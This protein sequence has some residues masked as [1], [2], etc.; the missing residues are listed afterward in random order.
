MI[1]DLPNLLLAWSIQATGVFSPGPGV[2]FILG[3]ATTAGRK[4]AL[5]AC[6]G[7]G[8]GALLLAVLTV[9]GFAAILAE[10]RPLLIATRWIGAAYLAWLAIGAFRRAAAPPPPPVA[11]EV[12]RGEGL[13]GRVLGGFIFQMGNPKA[14]FFWIAVAAV[15]ALDTVSTTSLIVFLA[16][17][18]VISFAGHGGWA[19]LLSSAPFRALYAR[20]RRWIEATLGAFFGLFALNLALGR[21]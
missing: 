20:A 16:G 18:F 11:A 5:A 3:I 13:I 8:F 12:A 7:I 21:N 15:G 1:A 4:P 19:V 14:I 17:A 6:L 10:S 2:A 9:L